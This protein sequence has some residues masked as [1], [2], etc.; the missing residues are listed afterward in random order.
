MKSIQQ[1]EIINFDYS[2]YI[3]EKQRKDLLVEDKLKGLKVTLASS[4]Q[5]VQRI[6]AIELIDKEAEQMASGN[7]KEEGFKRNRRQYGF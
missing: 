5:E 3:E 4:N 1:S 7:T 6:R 2:K